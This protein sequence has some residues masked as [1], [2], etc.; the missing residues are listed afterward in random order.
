MI[1]AKGTFLF[2]GTGASTGIPRIA[3]RCTVCRSRSLYNHRLRSSGLVMIQGKQFLLDVGPDFRQQALKHQIVHLD[4]VLITHTHYDHIGGIDDLRAIYFHSKHPISCLLSKESFQDLKKR[5]SY[6]F[7]PS[8]HHKEAPSFLTFQTVEERFSTVE[9]Q[10][11]PI[12]TVSYSQANMIVT[13][14][15]IGNFAYI[16]DI[17][18]YDEKKVFSA[19]QGVENLVLSALRTTPSPVQFTVQEAI[20][21]AQKIGAKKT[22]LTHIAHDLDHI[23]TAKTLPSGIKLGYDGLKINFSL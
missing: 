18:E 1:H 11:I 5:Y 20:D 6:F 14:F 10:G 2:L 22:W 17:R 13:G 9:F 19:L 4:G 3:C 8:E 7:N 12:Q 16:S 15:R 21:F 23:K